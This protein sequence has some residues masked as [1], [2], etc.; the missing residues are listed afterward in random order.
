MI[1][2]RFV[3]FKCANQEHL[4]RDTKIEKFLNMFEINDQL[5]IQQTIINK[6]KEENEQLKEE[7][8]PLKQK[9]EVLNKIWRTY[10]ENHE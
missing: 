6:L 7:I 4:I 9:E 10:L 8:E 3:L 5:N 1:E 2:K